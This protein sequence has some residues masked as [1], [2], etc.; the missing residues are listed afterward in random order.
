MP[1]NLSLQTKLKIACMLLDDFRVKGIN[2]THQAILSLHAYNSK[3]G[4]IVD[5]GDRLDV[6]PIIEGMYEHW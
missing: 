3:S 4:I 2:L 1:R 6:I 5:I